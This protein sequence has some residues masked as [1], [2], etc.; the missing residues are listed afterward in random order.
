MI[1]YD[2]LSAQGDVLAPIAVE[3]GDYERYNTPAYADISHFNLNE[4]TTISLV[5]IIDDKR[6][7][8][9]SQID[10]GDR[11]ILWWIVDG[12]TARQRVRHYE[13]VAS[14]KRHRPLMKSTD[15]GDA[16]VIEQED[17]P[18]YAYQ[19]QKAPTPQV[20]PEIFSRAGYIHPLWSP[21][22]QVLTR[23]Q[24][25]DHYH[26]YGIW[27]PWTHTEFNGREVDFW[28]LA[29]D[30]GRVDVSGKPAV[31][32][33]SIY[34]EIST[35]HRHIVHA[36]SQYTLGRAYGLSDP[37]K[38]VYWLKQAAMSGHRE[39]SEYLDKW[40]KVESLACD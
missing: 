34:G 4:S 15:R 9:N 28:N 1:L 7:V 19:Y 37:E 21:A 5:E 32:T 10:R 35:V 36:D 31:K 40:C 39:A 38:G 20:I 23:I 12:R 26:H 27:N 3:S 29:K 11:T 16:V 14:E 25:P 30:Q 2:N 17:K 18:V 22:G 8:I 6:H 13:I 33:V 24:P